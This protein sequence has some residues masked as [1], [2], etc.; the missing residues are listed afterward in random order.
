[1]SKIK[2]IETQLFTPKSIIRENTQSNLNPIV[3]GILATVDTPN[4]NGRYYSREIWER[5]LEK[6]IS[7][8]VR[9]NRALGELDHCFIEGY[10]ILTQEKGWVDFKHLEGNEFVATLN[11]TNQVLEYQP[12]EDFIHNPD[13]KGDIINIKSKTFQASITPNHKFLVTNQY[14]ISK[15]KNL[16]FKLAKDITK[17]DLIPKKSL[18]IKPPQLEVI[19]NNEFGEIKIPSKIF[20][21]FMGWWLS[22][23]SINKSP[24]NYTVHIPQNINNK[25]YL[26]LKKNLVSLTNILGVNLGEHKKNIDK[27]TYCLSFSN[28]V[29]H[30]Y[31][32]QFG[33]C[34]EKFIP[35]EIKSLD[36]DNIQI[37]LE[38]YLLGDGTSQYNQ[39]VYYTT[40]YQMALDLSELINLTGWASSISDKPL[41]YKKY[42][43]E[44]EWVKDFEWYKFKDTYRDKSILE[45][46]WFYTGRTLYS[47]R[48]KY[49]EYYHM[50]DCE[51][52]TEYY[53]GDIYCVTVPNHTILV[54]SPNGSTFWSGN[55]DTDIINL[56]NASHII[57]HVWWD[58]DNIMGKVEILPTPAGNIL[59]T[60]LE[61]KVLLG[62]SSRGM[63]SVIQSGELL[64][65]QDD[66]ELVCWD[67]VSTPSNPGSW[68]RQSLNENKNYLNTFNKYSKVNNILN[69]IIYN[70]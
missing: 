33:V 21:S 26:D 15:S 65:V 62:I 31:L 16:K 66:F 14:D 44:G 11:P 61:N 25:G 50:S 22:E 1:M 57:K 69:D 41:R 17:G 43:I 38:S 40:S 9:E 8:P 52:N 53:E 45:E 20:A 27:Y 64:E 24:N 2:L 67:F 28:K 42:L 3:E 70:I 34:D 23:G 49:S 36:K 35:K 13:Y 4:G 63:G 29:L 12:I 47:I 5:E 60:L 48:R 51:I 18:Y 55:S 56:K 68:M 10:K 19:I 46:E 58:G 59:K 39:E 37:F 30:K 6:Y 54:M 7:G 32:S